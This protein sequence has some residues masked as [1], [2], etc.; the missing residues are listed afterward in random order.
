[1]SYENIR[2][3]WFETRQP[4]TL[5][6]ATPGATCSIN[7]TW[8]NIRIPTNI[9]EGIAMTHEETPLLGIGLV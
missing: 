1:M 3:Q 7:G 8:K 9:S 4:Q 5:E 2:S 6:E